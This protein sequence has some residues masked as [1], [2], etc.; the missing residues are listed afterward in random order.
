[1][2]Y[3]RSTYDTFERKNLRQPE[4]KFYIEHTDCCGETAGGVAVGDGTRLNPA[5]E[6]T[7]SRRSAAARTRPRSLRGA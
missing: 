2:G 5:F 6:G 4:I 3:Q 1:M 7:S